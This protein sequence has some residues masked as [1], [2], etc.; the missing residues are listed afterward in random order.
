[1]ITKLLSSGKPVRRF[2]DIQRVLDAEGITCSMAGR[3][4]K[5]LNIARVRVPAA[6]GIADDTG[7]RSVFAWVKSKPKSK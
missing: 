5:A 6:G 4:K 2:P 3:V 1:V 7:G